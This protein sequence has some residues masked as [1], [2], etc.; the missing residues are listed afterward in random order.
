M[1]TSISLRQLIVTCHSSGYKNFAGRRSLEKLYALTHL[2][3]LLSSDHDVPLVELN[4]RVR[5][6]VEDRVGTTGGSRTHQLPV[7]GDELVA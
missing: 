3:C 6:F 7:V 1:H 4:V 2:G 5:V